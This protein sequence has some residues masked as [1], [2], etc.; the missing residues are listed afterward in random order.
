[1]TESDDDRFRELL[2]KAQAGDD[3]ARDRLFDRLGRYDE[4]GRRM[5]ALARRVLPVGDHA[6]RFVESQDLV[7]SALRCG[8]VD[9]SQF[10]GRSEG[11]FFAWL[12]QILARRLN[13]VLRRQRP[14]VGLHATTPGGDPEGGI[15]ESP[16]GSMVRE[17]TMNRM[18]ALIEAL[19]DD[20]RE[21]MELR[22]EGLDS[23]AIGQRLDLRP[24]A[25]R[26]RVSR[27]LARLRETLT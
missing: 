19:P 16:L 24:D 3:E 14:D 5:L 8:W 4:A 12:R 9:L 15:A 10:Q 23:R 22:L 18:R 13:R 1:M 21:V 26:K 2:E 11:E 6:R 20:L 25:V 17:E 7:Q 27:A